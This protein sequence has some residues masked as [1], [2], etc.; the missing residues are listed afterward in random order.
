MES[1]VLKYIE[2]NIN[3]DELNKL[4]ENIIKILKLNQRKN[5]ND[6][7]K[8]VEFES[9][10]AE[11]VTPFIQQ[12]KKDF[13]E[14]KWRKAY[15]PIHKIIQEETM[16][17]ISDSNLS[18]LPF[19]LEKKLETD[20]LYMLTDFFSSMEESF[21]IDYQNSLSTNQMIPYLR[22]NV[23]RLKSETM[24]QIKRN[25]E[26]NYR[27]HWEELLSHEDGPYLQ[28]TIRNE[29]KKHLTTQ[30]QF[31][32]F[33]G[34]Q[35]KPLG[36]GLDDIG[37]IYP[38][39]SPIYHQIPESN[40]LIKDL[41]SN[42]ALTRACHNRQIFRSKLGNLFILDEANKIYRPIDIK[43]FEEQLGILNGFVE[44]SFIDQKYI[45]LFFPIENSTRFVRVIMRNKN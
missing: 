5:I 26:N 32:E 45:D 27:E 28:K 44:N 6:L 33:T 15:S 31:L 4:K 10:F 7:E 14:S 30:I 12:T 29:I 39:L 43:T 34:N 3:N 17:I 16:R 37:E 8:E 18:N 23:E 40:F 24:N 9:Y 11:T 42:I 25:I 35:L 13:I 2:K 19:N 21:Y 1:L 22:D 36:Y 41:P 20:T 38:L